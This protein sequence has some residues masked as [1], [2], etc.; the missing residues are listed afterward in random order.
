[1]IRK[2]RYDLRI[3]C[4]LFYPEMVSTGQTLTELAEVLSSYGMRLKV[5]AS[6]PTILWDSKIVPKTMEYENITIKRTWSTRL[7]KLSFLGKLINLTT[8]FISASIEVLI[9]DKKVPLLLLTN[10]PYLSMLGRISKLMYNTTYG[11]LLHD[12]MP[13]QAELLNIIKP[14]GIFSKIWRAIN[15]FWYKKSSYVI[16]L[17]RDMLEGALENANLKSS[18]DEKECR[19]KT[20]VIHIWSD[21]RV[22]KPMLKSESQIAID[23]KVIDKFVVQY[24]GNH[25]RFHDIETLINITKKLVKNDKIIFQFI[26]EGYKKKMVNDYIERDKPSNIYTSTYVSKD[27]LNESLAMADIGVVAQMPGQEK[28][29]YPSKLLGIMSSGRAILAIC[30]RNCEMGKMI[31]D[32]ELGFVI[33]NGNADAAVKIINMCINDPAIAKQRGMNAF[34]YLHQNFTIDSAVQQY[35]KIIKSNSN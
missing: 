5:I 6:Q 15:H 33:D 4:Q 8:F 13:Q 17:S 11:V 16:V 29:C 1:M 24:S 12:I 10:P 25:G 34:N 9:H 2:N 27:E 3:V 28:V 19:E 20:H 23:L 30:S 26:G 22:I 32:N 21:D 35:Y 7:S 31:E 14:N 18:K